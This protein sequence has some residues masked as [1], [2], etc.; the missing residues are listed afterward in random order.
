MSRNNRVLTILVAPIISLVGLGICGTGVYNI[1][2]SLASRNWPSTVAKIDRVSLKVTKGSSVEKADYDSSLTENGNHTVN[3]DYHF[4]VNNTKYTDSNIAFGYSGNDINYSN[5]HILYKLVRSSSVKVRYNPDN[6]NQST[7]SSGLYGANVVIILIF[8]LT[9]V[10]AP[11][12]AAIELV[13]TRDE[14]LHSTMVIVSQFC[15]MACCLILLV[16]NISNPLL[17]GSDSLLNDLENSILD[18]Q[19]RK[20]SIDLHR[21]DVGGQISW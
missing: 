12:G 20:L 9:F 5:R 15:G 14:E 16:Q 17:Q 3:I 18:N 7:I 21:N 8:G 13:A 4:I 11:I 19:D 10:L 1:S 2:M 6:P